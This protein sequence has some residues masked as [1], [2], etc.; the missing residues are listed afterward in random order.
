[1]QSSVYNNIKIIIHQ[2]CILGNS[3]CEAFLKLNLFYKYL[4]FNNIKLCTI[5]FIQMRSALYLKS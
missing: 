5:F 2:C 3:W 4:T 1:M